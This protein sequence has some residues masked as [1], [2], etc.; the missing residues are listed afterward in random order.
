ME[1]IWLSPTDYVTG[2]P[3]LRISYPFVSHPST[4]VTSTAPGD[5]KWV[6]IGLR[7]PPN[8]SIE[9]IIICYQISNPNP[10]IP[11]K[12]FISQARLV[13][14]S[15][16]N[17]AI[18][19]H[20]DPT[21]LK[22]ITPTY[23]P[24][25]VGGYAPSAAVTLA[26]RLNFQN[27]TDQ[28][29]L[30][31][32]GVKFDTDDLEIKGPR[33]WADVR[34]YGAKGDGQTVND[35]VMT[36]GTD[37]LTSQ[38]G[39]FTPS[40]VGKDISV[41][42]A[43]AATDLYTRIAQ[44]ISD[45]EV[46]LD[47]P[48]SYAVAGAN[49]SWQSWKTNAQ[50]Q[51]I[52]A[53]NAGSN[54]LTIQAGSFTP[55][56]NGDTIE[57]DRISVVGA[58]PRVLYSTIA[59]FI[60]PTQVRLQ[61]VAAND[62]NNAT[63]F[64]GTDDTSAIQAAIDAANA[65]GGGVV[66]F[67]AGTYVIDG[68]K[69]KV[70][71]TC[72]AERNY[73]VALRSDIT[74]SGVGWKSILRLKDNSTAGSNDPQMFFAGP[75]GMLSNVV[76]E[77]L[78]FHGNSQNNLLG[79]AVGV[80]GGAF[81]DNRNCC[82]ICIGS[83]CNGEG[84]SLTGLTVQN[85]YF[86]DFPGANVIL[87]HDRQ[88]S[89]TFS[90]D[91]LILGN[92]FYDNRK[93]DGN[94]DHSTVN[95]F[96][97]NTRI[98]GNRF[99][100]PSSATDWQKQGTVACEL[101]GSASCFNHNT[102]SYYAGSAL[103]SENLHHDCLSQE[104][105]GNVLSNHGY[106]GFDISI[107]GQ[108]KTV[109]QINIVGNSV[110]FGTVRGVTNQVLEYSDLKSVPNYG[111]T[112]FPIP[113]PK[114]GVIFLIGKPLDPSVTPPV[115]DSLNVTGNTFDGDALNQAGQVVGVAGIWGDN[116]D[117]WGLTHLNICGNTFRR[118]T[119]GIWQDNGL[120]SVARHTTIVGNRFEDLRDPTT[121]PDPS[122]PVFPPAGSARAVYINGGPADR[123]GIMSVSASGNSLVN[124]WNDPTYEYGFYFQGKLFYP[125]VGEN[126]YY[127]IKTAN[128]AFDKP[129]EKMVVSL[130]PLSNRVVVEPTFAATVTIDPDLGGRFMIVVSN[131]NSF[132]I[133]T[134]QISGSQATFV[135]GTEI[136]IMIRNASGGT[137]GDVTWGTGY[138][139]S[140]SNSMDKPA[141]TGGGFII[142]LRFRYDSAS[143][144]WLEVAKGSNAVPS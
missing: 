10:Q 115:L 142:T 24:S 107:S 36:A 60:S 64:W 38:S 95:I 90:N 81:G 40:D 3:S 131:T 42:G 105:V 55:D 126:W 26:L 135:D 137:L 80:G 9:E 14:M 58:A 53:M 122:S 101:H 97:D 12:S 23:Y 48:A 51:G 30:G 21:D 7:L 19:R 70:V 100:L 54:R 136:E 141:G 49:I 75:T 86:T 69:N 79:A 35:G 134:P 88:T 39:A 102:L 125:S 25:K 8:V 77:N 57:G 62:A 84:V 82:A 121:D 93:A 123:D 41:A 139:T 72:G 68:A 112:F 83:M 111:K 103:F 140:W 89:G 119:Y 63:V 22:S 127:Q 94:R 92:T 129:S 104:G 15:T 29:L 108:F 66:F 143:G 78:A 27:T 28:I 45:T 133:N 91:V 1:T 13:E 85:C 106:R 17:Q 114:W 87:V 71:M 6:S 65:A 138:R 43:G 52:G 99:A 124:E 31:A 130:P 128:I 117:G 59:Q 11:P 144:M 67:P 110:H 61:A 76:F 116:R 20:D 32:V 96:A 132:T 98:I 37:V 4:I 18:V 74:L 56:S 50:T 16:P 5:L 33:P 73:G 120:L 34:A 47:T 2:D 109:K 118:L 46:A 113:F 44:Y